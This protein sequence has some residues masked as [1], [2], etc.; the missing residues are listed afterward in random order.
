MAR[1]HAMGLISFP[2]SEETAPPLFTS[3]PGLCKL[4]YQIIQT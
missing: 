4:L 2:E 1:H 3:G